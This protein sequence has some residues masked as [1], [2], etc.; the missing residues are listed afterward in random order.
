MK[1]RA[2]TLLEISIVLVIASTL[3][4]LGI[5]IGSFFLEQNRIKSTKIKLKTIANALDIYLI[6]NNKLPC[7]AGLKKSTGVPL[8]NCSSTNST[9]G[10][11]VSNE[12]SRGWVP[13]K[14]LNLTADTV[15]DEWG[16]KI[17]Y[18]VANV[19]T[20]KFNQLSNTFNGINIYN[21]SKSKLITSKAIYSINS[22]G[23]NGFG[24]YNKKNNQISITNISDLEKTNIAS[25]S[26]NNNDFLYFNNL[27]SYDDLGIYTTKY[28][29]MIDNEMSNVS[30]YITK[31]II[32][33]LLN[34]Y[35][36]PSTCDF[37]SNIPADNF[38]KF[39]C[40]INSSGNANCK[41]KY[42]IICLKYG[43]LG[44]TRND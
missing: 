17:T 41:D 42:K 29:V 19:A 1:N 25:S 32:T 2:F 31:A 39:D 34:D 44:V 28:Q 20:Y 10:V 18:T 6:Q 37:D 15:Y 21:D 38:L 40:T 7:P 11:F 14:E 24:A 5:G 9:E 26:V 43:R 8:S 33:Q 16:N 3:F 13:Y 30:C 35:G 4:S 22:H 36:A 23:K 12:V 27:K